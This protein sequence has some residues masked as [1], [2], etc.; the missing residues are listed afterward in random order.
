MR[1]PTRCP[2]CGYNKFGT[3]PQC[4]PVEA[5]RENDAD[6]AGWLAGQDQEQRRAAGML[7]CP[8]HDEYDSCFRLATRAELGLPERPMTWQEAMDRLWSR[9]VP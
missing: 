7:R 3:C 4:F 8:E 5:E 2:G 1:E 6:R 9:Y